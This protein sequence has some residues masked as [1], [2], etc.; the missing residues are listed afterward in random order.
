M[1]SN[2][3]KKLLGESFTIAVNRGKPP[4]YPLGMKEVIHPEY[5][6]SGPDSLDLEAIELYYFQPD[7]EYEGTQVYEHLINE[8]LLPH[9]LSLVDGWA[10][11][12]NES[13]IPKKWRDLKVVLWKSVIDV[14][15]GGY[16]VP[17]IACVEGEWRM[18]WRDVSFP[19]S[20]PYKAAI[21][22]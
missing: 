10:I 6:R 21:H 12:E 22:S 8:G 14:P 17:V 5:E 9:C 19:W 15:A 3:A 11:M 7:I 18:Y 2:L 1:H 13:L 16:Y 4:V 20:D